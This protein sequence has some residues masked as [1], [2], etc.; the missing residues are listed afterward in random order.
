MRIL[1]QWF[2]F[3]IIWI[4]VSNVAFSQERISIHSE[5]NQLIDAR[6][7]PPTQYLNGDV[8]IYHS[9][10][11]MY[12]DTAILRG[13]QLRMKHNVVLLQNDT[14]RIFADSMLYDGDRLIA[15]LYGDI[16]LEN[17]YTKKLYTTSLQY[18]LKNKIAYY[19]K[20][21]LLQDG[22]S[23]L[24]S[25]RGRYVLNEKTAY[26]YDDVQAIGDKF[27]LLTDS[28]AYRT[29]NQLATFLAPVNIH[30]D[31]AQIYSE[32][33]WFDLDVSSGEFIG[34]AQYL[35]KGTTAQGDTIRYDGEFDVVSLLSEG[36]PSHY[37]SSQDT[38]YGQLIEFDRKNDAYHI[39][40]DGFYK[41]ET[42][43]VSGQEIS[44]D[45]KTEK[46]KVTGRSKVSDPP[47]IIEADALDYD[48]Q[49]QY[50]K[51]DG[52]VIWQDTSAKTAV[53]AD[54]VL[55]RGED[56]FVLI[57]ND[58]GRPL[59]TSEME[60][61]TLFMRADTF[62]TFRTIQE[63]I[64]IQ[65]RRSRDQNMGLDEEELTSIQDSV[66]VDNTLANRDSIPVLDENRRNISTSDSLEWETVLADSSTLNEILVV[67]NDT[68]KLS[69]GL[70]TI[71]TG[72]MDTLDYFVGYNNVRVFKTNLQAVCDS[73]VFS[74]MDSILTLYKL[75]FVWSDTSQI[76]GDTM[77]VFV[78]SGKIEK[79][80]A[81]SNSSILSTEDFV[82]YDQIQGR[83]IDAF[84]EDN[85]ITTMDING[86]V[87]VVYY[88]KDEDKGYIG[89]NVTESA[90][91]RVKFGDSE[92]DDIYNYITP[93]SR[94]YPMR[95]ANHEALRIKNFFWNGTQRPESK[96]DL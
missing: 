23:Q 61:D 6:E 64:I 90:T 77:Q 55:Y 88:L 69:S 57:T 63:R 56:N 14:I 96:D 94:I 72:I 58:S 35:E 9:G 59:V 79:A 44:Y 86:N 21:A 92:I 15:D 18:D 38:V 85:Q 1:L 81:L 87:R 78:K 66:L 24:I 8:K 11:F 37:F 27:E 52:N 5:D 60:G 43:E 67:Q 47:M 53:F 68:L 20:N 51:A 89:V 54:H 71:Y 91:M 36:H 34:N 33:G 31:S 49:I 73:I 7:T 95:T 39:S 19:D 3:A 65:D 76:A 84:F 80:R 93:Q 70:D 74:Q 30:M 50:G 26:F 22:H 62:R 25:R 12:C 13:N 2:W 75:P 32:S 46:F 29:D 45:K 10:T 28:I 41:N 16:I 48:R 42:N 83:Y 4:V 82:F 40:G 17:G